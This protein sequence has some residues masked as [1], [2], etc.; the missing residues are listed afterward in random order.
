M[1]F[2]CKLSKKSFVPKFVVRISFLPQLQRGIWCNA[3]QIHFEKRMEK[4]LA[5]LQ[6]GKLSVTDVAYHSGFNDI[7]TLVRALKSYSVAL[8]N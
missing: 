4:S 1:P 2:T 7:Y 5:L 3:A 8:R 6:E